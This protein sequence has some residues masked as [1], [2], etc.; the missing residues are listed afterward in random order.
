MLQKALWAKRLVERIAARLDPVP[1]AADVIAHRRDRPCQRLGPVILDRERFAIRIEDRHE[2]IAS[3][4]GEHGRG[5]RQLDQLVADLPQG[6]RE[7][8]SPGIHGDR[9]GRAIF[10]TVAQP[11]KPD[12][13]PGFRL[14]GQ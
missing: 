8:R 3:R 4:R 9:T 12:L 14:G 6:R 11:H 13:A 7:P 1:S 10:G 2:F 5:S